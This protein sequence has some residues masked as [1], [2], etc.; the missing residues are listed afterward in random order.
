MIDDAGHLFEEPGALDDVAHIA[1]AWLVRT[2]LPARAPA[3]IA[4]ARL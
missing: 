3:V 1:G 2:L 4:A